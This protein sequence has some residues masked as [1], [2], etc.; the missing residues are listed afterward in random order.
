MTPYL[1][2]VDGGGTRTTLA[3]AD[4]SGREILRRQGPAGLVDPRHPMASVETLVAL[5]REATTEADLCG[6][7]TAFCAGLAGVG[8]AAEREAVQAGIEAVGVAER[9]TIVCDGEVALEGALGNGA[10]ILLIAG[11]GSIAYGRGEDGR[12]ERCGGW[13]MVVGD[14]GSGY[15]IGRA[16]L[17][18]ALHAADG[19][20]AP[21]RLL[22]R[23]L[24]V[25]AIPGPE[26]IPS[27]AGRAEKADVAALA[28]HVVDL[29]DAGDPV[30]IAVLDEASVALA[31]HAAALAARIGPW[32]R[33][34]D[35]VFHGGLLRA[36]T[37]SERVERA[38]IERVPGFRL[39]PAAAD[40]ATGA[41]RFAARMLQP[42]PV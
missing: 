42:Q 26:A 19:R 24:E 18:A 11:T 29:A 14:E 12:M 5:L 36:P 38:I 37:Y 13:G 21:T 9:V 23:L 2:G 30:S 35:I 22:P 40:A 39:R 32:P 10:G 1:V 15:G 7:A 28:A 17:R 4:G 20:G 16:A 31:L 3:L 6:P 8:N 25:L 27:W 34:P 41:L 33:G